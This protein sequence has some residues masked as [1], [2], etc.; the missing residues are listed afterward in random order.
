VPE[1]YFYLSNVLTSKKIAKISGCTSCKFAWKYACPTARFGCL[2][3]GN[4]L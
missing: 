2:V 4:R 1:R 3:A